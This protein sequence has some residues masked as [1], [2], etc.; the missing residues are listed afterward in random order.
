MVGHVVRM[1]QGRTVMK[2]LQSKLEGSGR[3]RPRVR[4]PEDMEKD[5]PEMK[6]KRWR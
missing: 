1:D 4:W 6:V 5:L 3:G 2:V